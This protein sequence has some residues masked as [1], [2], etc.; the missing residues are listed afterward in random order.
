M[1]A[2]DL[3]S[4]EKLEGILEKQKDVTARLDYLTK[5]INLLYEKM[6]VLPSR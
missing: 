1:L 5:F 6:H 3:A 2:D 4:F